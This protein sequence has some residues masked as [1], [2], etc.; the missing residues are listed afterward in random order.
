MW[1]TGGLRSELSCRSSLTSFNGCSE[2]F[3]TLI[4]RD[5]MLL[6]EFV[7]PAVNPDRPLLEFEGESQIAKFLELKMLRGKKQQKKKKKKKTVVKKKCNQINASTEKPPAWS[8]L[9]EYI[10]KQHIYECHSFIFYFIQRI[11]GR[12]LCVNETAAHSVCI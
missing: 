11:S 6:V 1:V 2:T 7:V 12:V 3:L 8:P 10:F 9:G 5:R 4:W